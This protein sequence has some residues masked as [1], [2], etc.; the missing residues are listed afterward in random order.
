[1]SLVCLLVFAS[2]LGL[3]IADGVRRRFE[4]MRRVAGPPASDEE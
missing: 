3:T 4:K 2:G 1:M